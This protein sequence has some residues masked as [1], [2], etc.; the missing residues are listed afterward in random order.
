MAQDKME[1]LH[2][3][4]FLHKNVCSGYLLEA[5]CQGASKEYCNIFFQEETRNINSKNVK[6]LL[7]RTITYISEKKRETSIEKCALLITLVMLNK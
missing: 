1:S 6:A 3:F 4:L 2:I 5:F 7:M